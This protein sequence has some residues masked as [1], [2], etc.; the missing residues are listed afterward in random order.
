MRSINDGTADDNR[1]A[2]A[3]APCSGIQTW[4]K[5]LKELSG[6]THQRWLAIKNKSFPD[7]FL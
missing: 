2:G 3:T 7:R 1:H 5:Q 6:A 4:V